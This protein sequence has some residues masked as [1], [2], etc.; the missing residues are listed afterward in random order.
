MTWALVGALLLRGV[1]AR[2][3][4]L[5]LSLS[6]IAVLCVRFVDWNSRKPFLKDLY[7]VKAGMT[8]A[9]V[10]EVMGRYVVGSGQTESIERGEMV[11]GS[12]SYRHT[13]EAW[14]NSD[15]GTITFEGGRV[16]SVDFS[17]D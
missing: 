6:V 8:P 17:P 16:V 13:Q 9:Q 5:I 10:E 4:V 12:V 1:S 11:A 3:R 14:G 15:W 7:S 2:R